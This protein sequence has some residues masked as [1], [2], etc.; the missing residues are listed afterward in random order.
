VARKHVFKKIVFLLIVT[1]KYSWASTT[2]QIAVKDFSSKNL[3]YDQ[4]AIFSDR[5]RSELLKTGCFRVMEREE[6]QSIL[7]EQGFQQTGVCDE[8]SCIVETGKILGVSHIVAGSIGKL[9]K[10]FICDVR[11]INVLTGEIH[12]TA[13]SDCECTV[14]MVLTS[15]LVDLAEKLSQSI[16][17][18]EKQE[19]ITVAGITNSITSFSFIEKGEMILIGGG[20]FEMGSQSDN[21]DSDEKHLHTVT[22][23]SFWIDKYEVTQSSYLKVMGKNP[24]YFQNCPR[25]PVESVSWID[26]FEYCKKN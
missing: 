16:C 9:G 18:A 8:K 14:E 15:S 7:K 10:M 13:T 6:M 17:A 11:L 2:L 3:P 19:K 21:A 26:A 23:D 1:I 4:I 24:S 22:V 5:F 12:T 25:C 20:T